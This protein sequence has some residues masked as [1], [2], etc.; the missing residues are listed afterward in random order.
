MPPFSS[1][2]LDKVI[3]EIAKRIAG[4]WRPIVAIDGTAG[5]GKS[6]LAKHAARRLNALHLE[7]DKCLSPGATYLLGYAANSEFDAL[8]R[9]I[10]IAVGG[11][12][13]SGTCVRDALCGLGRDAT[14]HVY[15]KCWNTFQ[16]RWDDEEVCDFAAISDVP[17]DATPRERDLMEYHA[18]WQPHRRAQVEWR[19]AAEH[20]PARAD[21]PKPGLNDK[22]AEPGRA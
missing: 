18:I 19:N 3:S 7:L 13:L 16:N 22:R 4:M 2:D 12:I 20:L 6:H 14:V 9:A 17:S 11:V 1:Q 8:R 10:D 15:V 5:V 21:R